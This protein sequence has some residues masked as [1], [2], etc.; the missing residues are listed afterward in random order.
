MDTV[1]DSEIVEWITINDEQ[2]FEVSELCSKLLEFIVK[3]EANCSST[4]TTSTV[5]P[6]LTHT[7]TSCSTASS[8]RVFV[9]MKSNE[10]VESLIKKSWHPY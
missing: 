6:S 3:V 9:S 10:E 7:S 5:S 2:H 1:Y 8:D 4:N